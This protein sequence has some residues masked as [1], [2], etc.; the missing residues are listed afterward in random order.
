MG[1]DQELVL[2]L[3]RHR[4]NPPRSLLAQ[5]IFADVKELL[6]VPAQPIELGDDSRSQ[7]EFGG[8]ELIDFSGLRVLIANAAKLARFSEPN[9]LIGEDPLVAANLSCPTP[10]A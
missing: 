7:M 1:Q 5:K 4:T 3:R 2:N 8:Q 6:D 10:T 9:P